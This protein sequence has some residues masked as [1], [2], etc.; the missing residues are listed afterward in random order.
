MPQKR[1]LIVTPWIPYPI[2]G[3]D[4]QDRFAGFLQMK[5]ISSAI[6]VIAKIHAFQ[7]RAEIQKF[8]AD[9]GIPL[10][11]VPYTKSHIGLFLRSLLK[12]FAEPALLDGAALEYTDKQL[13]KVVRD[14]VADFKPDVAWVEF[15]F[16]WPVVRLMRSLGIPTV[17]RSANNE[18]QQSIDEHRG[19]WLA[20]LFAIPKFRGERIAALESTMVLAI[21]PWEE[22]WYKQCGGKNVSVLPLRGLPQ[23]LRHHHHTEKDILNVVFL[24][25]S[26]TNGHNRDALEFILRDIVPSV[27]VYAP[28]TFQF[29]ITGKNFPDAFKKYVG[30]DILVHGFIDD[31]SVFLDTMDIAL[32]PSVS[33]QGMQQKIFEPLCCGLPLITHHT[34]GYAFKDKEH[35]CLT[36]SV[37]DYVQYLLDLRSMQ[38]RQE[39]ADN[40]YNLA[41]RL[42]SEECLMSVAAAAIEDSITRFHS[43]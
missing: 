6:H 13:E 43:V 11:L 3:A 16:L 19:N 29:H 39:L 32:C 34:A 1:V 42:F 21:T 24:G 4:Q 27:R 26:Y 17:M 28:G 14:A 15:S 23:T 20:P 9:A 5:K 8:Y 38:R 40:A 35:V 7:P 37:D 41:S 30:P 18:A 31:L 36:R 33:G 2:T 12:I 10:T 25:S 22:I